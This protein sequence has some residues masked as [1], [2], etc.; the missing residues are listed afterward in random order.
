M[1]GRKKTM[2]I[3]D[4]NWGGLKR[5]GGKRKEEGGDRKVDAWGGGKGGEAVR[6]EGKAVMQ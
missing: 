4:R 5:I 1:T 2:L 3:K 6:K